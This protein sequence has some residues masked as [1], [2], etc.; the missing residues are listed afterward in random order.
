M[1]QKPGTGKLH[2]PRSHASC[3]LCKEFLS[4]LRG[5]STYKGLIISTVQLC[6]CLRSPRKEVFFYM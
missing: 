1:L 4:S 2:V 5:F 3:S 6:L